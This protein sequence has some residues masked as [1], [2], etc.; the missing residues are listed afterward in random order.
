MSKHTENTRGSKQASHV[1][2]LA[3][4]NPRLAAT[5]SLLYAELARAQ[6]DEDQEAVQYIKDAIGEVLRG[7]PKGPIDEPLIQRQRARKP[8]RRTTR[9]SSAKPARAA[10]A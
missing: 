8:T 3:A 7:Q 10:A 2:E 1:A 6:S 4:E 5:L 9:K